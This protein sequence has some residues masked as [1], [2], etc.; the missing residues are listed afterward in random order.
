[1]T[2]SVFWSGYYEDD[3]DNDHP[4]AHRIEYLAPPWADSAANGASAV[5]DLAKD[6][7]DTGSTW[8]REFGNEQSACV[9]IQVHEPPSIAG[10]YRVEL[11]FDL[12]ARAA[13]DTGRA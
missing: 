13:R 5:S 10:F 11:E 4:F 3:E 2:I 7:F 6:W 1:M 8:R 12:V 9:T